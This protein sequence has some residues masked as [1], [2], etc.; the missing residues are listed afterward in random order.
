MGGG[1]REAILPM[2]GRGGPSNNHEQESARFW[3]SV[4]GH[5]VRQRKNHVDRAAA[6]KP[7][8]RAR[9][10]SVQA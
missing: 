7:F 5:R 2:S 4:T 9:T 6:E 10:G 1:N 8:A 3:T